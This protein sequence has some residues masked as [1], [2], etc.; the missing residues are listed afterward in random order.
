MNSKLN[1]ILACVISAA[2]V[3]GVS[4]TP[5]ITATAY[6]PDTSTVF[7]AVENVSLN[8]DTITLGKG[9]NYNLRAK[10]TPSDSSSKSLMWMSSNS[11]VA[12][13]DGNG[14]VI[15]K[16]VGTATIS[17]IAHN[18]KKS[19]C[20]VKVQEAPANIT[21]NYHNI[22]LGVGE[23]C[24]FTSYIPVNT[25]SSSRIYTSSDNKVASFVSGSTLA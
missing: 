24:K 23:S 10:I 7:T 6:A 3:T 18:G 15:A 20:Y 17:A 16:G 5:I 14:K 11:K 25:V 2:I 4:Y 22:E 1:N 21:L 8:R 9:D 12:Y 19:L 13:V